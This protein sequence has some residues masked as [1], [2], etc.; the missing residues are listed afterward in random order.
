M[1]KTFKTFSCK[2]N[3]QKGNI[4]YRE[5]QINRVGFVQIEDERKKGKVEIQ[6]MS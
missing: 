1:I 5:S 4:E 2:K 3:Q 6:V